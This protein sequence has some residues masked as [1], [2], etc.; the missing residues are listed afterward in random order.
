MKI[1]KKFFSL[2]E[3]IVV[4]GVFAILLLLTSIVFST[5]Q[6]AWTKSSGNTTTFENV[7]IAFEI[8]TRDIQSIYYKKNKIP[9][10]YKRQSG[11]DE[12]SN[13]SID[14]VAKTELPP[15]GATSS[16]CEVRYQLYHTNDYSEEN[17]G[18]LMR[19]VTGNKSSNGSNNSKW[20]FYKNLTVGLTGDTNAFTANNDS[21][22]SYQKLIPCVTNLSFSCYDENGNIVTGTT[23][24]VIQL[25]FSIE[26]NINILD[27][28]DWNKWV[29][30]NNNTG[31][32]TQEAEAFRKQNE[33]TFTKTILIG[34]RGQYY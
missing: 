7:R 4:M 21:G 26:V 13:E 8:I 31:T 1:Y 32:E 24:A 5:A 27:D 28:D 33:R 14:F 12:F 23:D 34:N 16:L 18:W 9:F 11:T 20:N 30:I 15:E 19:S 25:P 2:I 3:L 10:W 6:K 17:A 29:V 22:D